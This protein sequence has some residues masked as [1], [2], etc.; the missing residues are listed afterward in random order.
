M[1]VKSSGADRIQKQC[2]SRRAGFKSRIEAF[3]FAGDDGAGDGDGIRTRAPQVAF[4]S[5]SS[6]LAVI[7]PYRAMARV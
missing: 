1:G 4:C 5:F 7:A 2:I 6:A 3:R